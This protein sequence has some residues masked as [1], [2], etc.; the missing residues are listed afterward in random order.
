MKTIIVSLLLCI[1]AILSNPANA[2]PSWVVLDASTGKVLGQDKSNTPHGPASLAKMM[3]VYL[4]FE[5][6]EKGKLHWNDTIVVSKNAS[7]KIPLKLWLKP[8]S[9]I[10]VREAVNG[11]IVH[12]ANDAATAM[13]E[14]LGTT[15]AGFARQMTQR[16]RQLGMQNT[17]FRNPWG[18]TEK[19]QATTAYDMA[20]LAIALMRDF[21]KDYALFAQRSFVFRGK[22]I[23]G[24][25]NLMYRYA[26]V[27]GLKTGYTDASG[28]NLASSLVENNRRIVG[29]VLGGKTARSRDDQMAGLLAQYSSSAAPNGDLGN[30]L[31]A[32]NKTLKGGLTV[33]SLVPI[34]QSA[35]KRAPQAADVA[36]LIDESLIEQGD[37]GV[38]PL[39]TTNAWNIQIGAVESRAAADRLLNKVDRVVHSAIPGAGGFIE[40]SAKAGRTI[41]RVR[42]GRFEDA[43][44]AKN[45]CAELK[46]RSLACLPVRM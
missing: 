22:E 41:Y 6:L 26:G 38:V 40:S 37:G 9:T 8:G 17:V 46:R 1:T 3:T 19:G 45:A 18:M 34:P 7:Q 13:A 12:S 31:V 2:E 29:V 5:A 20:L 42:F 27:D 28:F 36:S 4:T 30:A 16:A 10:T 25:N 39:K 24:H 32:G 21:P 15:E 35:P 11:M 33:A 23:R 43:Q 44:A 14:H